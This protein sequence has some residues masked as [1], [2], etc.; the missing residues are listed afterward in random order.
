[1]ACSPAIPSMAHPPR[2]SA[3]SS[4]ATNFSPRPSAAPGAAPTSATG[5]PLFPSTTPPGRASSAPSGGGD[6]AVR[7]L[8]VDDHAVLARTVVE[9][10]LWA[11]EVDVVPSIAAAKHALATRAY[12]VALVD[13]DLEDG[14]GPSFVRWARARGHRLPLVAVS[15]HAEGN[16][17]L[18][19]AGAN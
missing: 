1:S 17:A 3:P 12:D 14:I 11:H 5:S 7:I 10:F 2:P 9:A 4:T 13:H 16:A 19:E 18:M 6:D 15:S 8:Y